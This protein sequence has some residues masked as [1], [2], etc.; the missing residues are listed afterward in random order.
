MSVL[1]G[2]LNR[3]S[4][5]QLILWDTANQKYFRL[6]LISDGIIPDSA[7]SVL[8]VFYTAKKKRCQVSV[9]HNSPEGDN[10]SNVLYVR[11]LISRFPPVRICAFMKLRLCVVL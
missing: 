8:D 1:E 4:S 3:I 9:T 10:F 5:D 2:G 11:S 7:V 6:W